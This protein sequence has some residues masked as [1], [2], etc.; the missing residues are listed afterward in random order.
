M[1][2]SF[3]IRFVNDASDATY[4]KKIKLTMSGPTSA[5]TTYRYWVK[6]VS[7]SGAVVK[8]YAATPGT[9]SPDA[10]SLSNATANFAVTIPLDLDGSYLAGSYKIYISYDSTSPSTAVLEVYATVSYAPKVTPSSAAGSDVVLSGTVSCITGTVT[11]TDE[12]DYSGYTM[13]SRSLML[14][15]PAVA[16]AATQPTDVTTGGGTV[17]T[18]TAWSGVT[19]NALL[20]VMRKVVHALP[21]D[22]TE[23]TAIETIEQTV[24]TVAI[25]V[26]CDLDFCGL[27]ACLEEKFLAVEDQACQSGGWGNV[28]SQEKDDLQRAMSMCHL[29]FTYHRCGNSAKAEEWYAK[30]ADALSCDCGCGCGSSAAPKPFTALT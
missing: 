29:A 18:V 12:T 20:T 28:S 5:G 10:T 16:G 9:T 3:Q 22:F 23:F 11:A 17:N 2:M 19:W 24:N 25:P 8:D 6:V 27:A 13:T 4:N 1:P 7:P 14:K 30:A 26:N 21:G 15:A